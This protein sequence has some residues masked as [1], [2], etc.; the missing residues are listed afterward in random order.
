MESDL[1]VLI[2]SLV[3]ID[4]LNESDLLSLVESLIDVDKLVE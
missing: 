3:D 2:Q 4:V 1:L